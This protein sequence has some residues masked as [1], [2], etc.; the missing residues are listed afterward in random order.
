M[1]KISYRSHMT[2]NDFLRLCPPEKN[3]ARDMRLFVARCG[4]RQGVDP[5]IDIWVVSLDI[6]D[7]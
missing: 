5:S 6:T 7:I 3:Q 1:P 4:A 2:N